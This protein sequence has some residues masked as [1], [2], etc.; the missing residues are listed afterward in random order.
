MNRFWQTQHNRLTSALLAPR[1]I[2]LLTYFRIAFGLLMC[3]EMGGY[4]SS[5]L[6]EQY[7][8]APVFHFTYEGFE[9]LHPWPGVGM[10]VHVIG[11]GVC[12]ICITLGFGYRWATVLFWLG[13]TYLFLLDQTTYLNQYYLIC[14][15]SFVLIFLPAHR[16]FSLDVWL[17]RTQAWREI[18]A[19][20][21]ACIRFQIG[22]VYVFGG[23]AKLNVDW[24]Q[25]EPVRMWLANL[26]EQS[27]IAGGEGSEVVVWGIAY[28]GLLF[29]LAIVPLLLWNRTRRIGLV[30][31]IGFHTINSQVFEIGLFPW[32]MMFVTLVFLP[33]HQFRKLFPALPEVSS[34]INPL[35]H[36]RLSTGLIVAL[37]CYCLI[38]ISIPLRHF[39]YPGHV[40][41][42]EEG[43][44]FSWR[45]KLREK[46]GYADFY[47]GEQGDEEMVLLDP[48]RYLLPHQYF[49]MC[50]R[51]ALVLQF[52]HFIG[53]SASQNATAPL[54]VKVQAVSSLNS[55]PPQYLILPDQNLMII[56]PR[57]PFQEW[58]VPLLSQ[59]HDSLSE[60]NPGFDLTACSK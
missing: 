14:C 7:W 28:G 52:A 10:Y 25:G 11:L 39:L 46:S 59:S 57:T 32:L 36:Q 40:S 55:R 16:M 34:V 23:I 5:G 38:Q 37:L 9:W 31:M 26:L 47:V 53:E 42:T 56:A 21:M 58:G 20:M 8:I 54:I 41:W 50:T 17:G 29:D 35:P 33:A 24:L 22:V 2:A 13:F 4:L 30:L 27:E 15:L 43:H 45:M 3:W 18:P 48:D 44:R 6:I 1:D 51:P 12:A 49:H 60:R 19:W